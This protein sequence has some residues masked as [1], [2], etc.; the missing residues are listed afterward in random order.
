MG[1]G[2]LVKIY[3]QSTKYD[4]FYLSKKFLIVD[5]LTKVNVLLVKD[6][7]GGFYLIRHPID[8]K[9][10]N[11]DITFDEDKN[12]KE[13]YDNELWKGAFDCIS[14]NVEDNDEIFNSQTRCRRSQRIRRPNPMY[15][16]LDYVE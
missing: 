7:S 11:R 6:P 8:L 15:F 13:E 3:K 9:R 1:D 4:P 10:V 14:Q 16:N 5:I 2:V 12:Q